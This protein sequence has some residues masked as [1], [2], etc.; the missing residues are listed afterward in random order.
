MILDTLEGRVD[1]RRAMALLFAMLGNRKEALGS[2]EQE[3]TDC[4]AAKE[5]LQ[6]ALDG[7]NVERDQAIGAN[8][9]CQQG[10]R[11]AFWRGFFSALGVAGLTYAG[12]RLG[13]P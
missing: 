1:Q 11:G 8:V 2:A 3:A 12:V 4:G 9:R 13:A 7:S 6:R 5:A 10:R